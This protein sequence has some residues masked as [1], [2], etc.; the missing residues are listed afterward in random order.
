MDQEQSSLVRK[1]GNILSLSIFGEKESVHPLWECLLHLRNASSEGDAIQILHNL[2][3][4]EGHTLTSVS[5]RRIWTL[6]CFIMW[7]SRFVCCCN[8]LYITR[9]NWHYK[10]H[11]FFGLEHTDT[12][13]KSFIYCTD[14]CN[15]I[16]MMT[17]TKYFGYVKDYN[18]VLLWIRAT[19]NEF[20]CRGITYVSEKNCQKI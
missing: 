14:A 4:R 18:G 7:Y 2:Y 19:F 8:I 9:Y 16:P 13:T 1:C 12:C 11:T 5:T 20:S 6:K 15:A 10:P 17:A 3:Y